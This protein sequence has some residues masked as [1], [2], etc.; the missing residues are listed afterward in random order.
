MDHQDKLLWRIESLKAYSR[1]E[2]QPQIKALLR[3]LDG[4]KQDTNDYAL[5]KKQ[6]HVI[7][8]KKLTSLKSLT[9]VGSHLFMHTS[10]P[11][12]STIYVSIGLGFHVAFTLEEADTW[13]SKKLESLNKLIRD[14]S[15]R[16]EQLTEE[17][18]RVLTSEEMIA[19]AK[20][21]MLDG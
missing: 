12:T 10:I 5:L 7:Q 13:I 6:I 2:L 11:D 21:S 17:L 9:D 3:K 4:L 15:Y 20:L 16:V 19:A 18:E 14:N 1:I 8:Q